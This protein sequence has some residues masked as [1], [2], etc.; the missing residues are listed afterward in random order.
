MRHRTVALAIGLV[1][2]TST[3]HAQQPVCI[4]GTTVCGQVGPDG[5]IVVQP[6]PVTVTGQGQGQGQGQTPPVQ[7]SG[8]SLQEQLAA[9]RLQWDAYFRWRAQLKIEIDLAV[10]ARL[11]LEAR[12]ADLAV[13]DPYLSRPLSIPAADPSGVTFPRFSLGLLALCFG[14]WTGP[15]APVYGGY[16]P[17]IRHRLGRIGIALDPSLTNVAE[18]GRQYLLFALRPGITYA[19][20]SGEGPLYGSELF[21]GAGG[22]AYVPF[23]TDYQTPRAFLGAHAALGVQWTG[24]TW[25]AG[26][27]WRATV[28]GGVGPGDDEASRA[29]ATFRAGTEARFW[30]AVEF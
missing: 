17:S 1:L 21:L 23:N 20:V 26:V 6:P 27:D 2:V 16:C 24:S 15:G 12:A 30:V 9:W 14:Q 7:L 13:P 29:M 3:A 18:A 28:R 4:P 10:A 25:A 19:L 11:R 8:P 22:D 5:K